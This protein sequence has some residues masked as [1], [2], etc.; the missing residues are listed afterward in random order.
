MKAI[1]EIL[2]EFELAKTKEARMAV[3][4]KNLS[5]TLVKVLELTYHPQINWTVKELPENYRVPTDMLPGITHD[6]LNAQLRRMYL[7]R[8][9]DPTAANLTEKRRN[10]LLI[11]ILESIEP[12][13]AE[14]VLGILQKD[15]GVKGLNY[16]FVKEAFPNLIP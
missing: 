7:F 14:V 6:S 16:K 12:R 4:E 3:I 9:G 5:A 11:Q 1:Y 2:D 13:E 8:D 15:L 10:E